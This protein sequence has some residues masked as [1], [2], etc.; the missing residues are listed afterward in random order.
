[1]RILQVIHGFPPEC[2]GGTELYCEGVGRELASRGHTSLV[3]AGTQES[4]PA[5]TLV[6]VD[7]EGLLVTRF[8]GIQPRPDHWSPSYRPEAERL[9]RGYLADVRPDI[10]HVQH[11]PRLTSNLV[12]I[13]KS[14]RIPTVVTLHDLWATC[15]RGNRL[16]WDRVFCTDPL[17]TAPCLSCVIRREGEEDDEVAKE[18]GLRQ[19]LVSEELRQADRVLVPSEAQKALL[20]QLLQDEGV[21]LQVLPHGRISRVT[22]SASPDDSMGPLLIGYWGSLV[23]WKGPHLLLEAMHH[24]PDP[25]M[26]EAHLFGR[27]GERDYGSH[28]EALAAG[29]AVVFHGSFL[30]ADL[31]RGRLHLAVFPSL[32]HE[33][34]SFVLDE[35]FQLGLPAI[36]PDRGAPALRVGEAG[37]IFKAGD[38]SDLARQIW[39]V[40]KEPGLLERL[41][42]GRPAVALMSLEDHAAQLEQIYGQVIA[43][44]ELAQCGVGER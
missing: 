17:P 12:T 33:S 37:L 41:R 43:S 23:W 18:L 42:R 6:T 14:L 16:R 39:R 21:R 31:H 44:A 4:R 3:L 13:C 15:P 1:M 32:C 28:L 22:P 40:V 9:I 30:P 20:D 34:H 5:P 11:W 35:A 19:R 7:Q 2:V 27:P 25:S 26:V 38:A 29:L 24:L 8:V 36:V 10:V